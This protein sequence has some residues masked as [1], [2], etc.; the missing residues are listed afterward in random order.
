MVLNIGHLTLLHLLVPTC[1]CRYRN[2]KGVQHGQPRID[3]TGT[4]KMLSRRNEDCR[5]KESVDVGG[6][7]YR[8][9]SRHRANTTPGREKVRKATSADAGVRAEVARQPSSVFAQSAY[10]VFLA[11]FRL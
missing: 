4:D 3:R 11:S 8:R 9:D 5:F 2:R 7:N 10:G 6:D 1:V